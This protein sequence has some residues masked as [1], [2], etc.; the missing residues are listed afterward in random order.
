MEAS[1]SLYRGSWD[2]S[3]DPRDGHERVRPNRPPA[4]GLYREHRAGRIFGG[5]SGHVDHHGLG[6]HIYGRKR[7]LGGGFLIGSTKHPGKQTHPSSSFPGGFKRCARA[8]DWKQAAATSGGGN[9]KG[10]HD[11]QLQRAEPTRFEN[12][13]ERAARVRIDQQRNVS[14][15]LLSS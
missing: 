13:G 12:D 1:K 9:E 4:Y 15:L 5:R 3:L 10:P 14:H 8:F 2:R 7:I 6:P 11:A